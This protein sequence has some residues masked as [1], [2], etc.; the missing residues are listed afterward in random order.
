M[1]RWRTTTP[2][3]HVLSGRAGFSLAGKKGLP[4]PPLAWV[5]RDVSK[6]DQAFVRRFIK[7]NIKHFSSESLKNATKYFE[8]EDLDYYRKMRRNV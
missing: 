6:H 1:S 2:T 5:L 8:K 4:R 7:E 3:T